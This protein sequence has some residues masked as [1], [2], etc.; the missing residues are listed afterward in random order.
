[1]IYLFILLLNF[2]LNGSSSSIKIANFLRIFKFLATF[3]FNVL[4]ASSLNVS[5][6][7]YPAIA[8]Y[9]PMSSYRSYKF[10]HSPC[11]IR[12]VIP[13]LFLLFSIFFWI[14]CQQSNLLYLLLKSSG[15][16]LPGY[17]NSPSS[18]LSF[19]WFLSGFLSHL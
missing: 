7:Q 12:Y 16:L 9:C 17:R 5:H 19:L 6:I 4:L 8:F 13:F 3:L 1:M 14:P 15:S 10:F 2:F 18:F 11:Y